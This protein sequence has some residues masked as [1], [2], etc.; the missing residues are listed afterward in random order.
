MSS[1]PTSVDRRDLERWAAE[2]GLPPAP[3]RYSSLILAQMCLGHEGRI[4]DAY[5]VIEEMRFLEGLKAVSAT[6]PASPF[7]R[8]P[9]A[10]FM[11]K[12]YFQAGFI[13]ANIASEYG[14][15]HGGNQNLDKLISRL[16]SAHE[17]ELVCGDFAK[18][19]AH[20]LTIVALCRRSARQRRT[21]EWIVYSEREHVRSYL[22]LASHR[23]GDGDIYARMKEQCGREFPGIFEGND[24]PPV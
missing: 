3:A 18:I 5:H 16:F 12:H 10:G 22:T 21:G 19:A 2:R 13:P 1:Q 17:G 20:E 6:K 8:P 7:Q 15:R 14:V 11:H 24:L 23:E 9:L 4:L